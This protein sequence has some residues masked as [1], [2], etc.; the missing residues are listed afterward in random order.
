MTQILTFKPYFVIPFMKTVMSAIPSIKTLSIEIYQII[1]HRT[2]SHIYQIHHGKKQR[3]PH[4]IFILKEQ[5]FLQF[6][7]K[8]LVA[9]RITTQ[10]LYQ[11]LRLI[12]LRR[13]GIHNTKRLEQRQHQTTIFTGSNHIN[14]LIILRTKLLNCFCRLIVVY[15]CFF[16][17]H[18]ILAAWKVLKTNH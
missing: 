15:P 13:K 1:R 18:G 5:G 16:I 17:A 11:L 3:I 14:I 12:Q 4:E 6:K 10:T 7:A 2:I 9:F 8:R